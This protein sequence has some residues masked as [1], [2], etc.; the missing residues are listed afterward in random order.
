M[1]GIFLL[2]H[3]K[4]RKISEL[5]NDRKQIYIHWQSDYKVC[6]IC[7]IFIAERRVQILLVDDLVNAAI[8]AHK[9]GETVSLTQ[10]TYMSCIL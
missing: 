8:E 4:N 6:N 2:I 10:V 7:F 1:R 5:F 3:S 9:S